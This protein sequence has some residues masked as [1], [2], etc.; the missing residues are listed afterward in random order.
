MD[1]GD[2]QAEKKCSPGVAAPGEPVERLV[3]YGLIARGKR[4]VARPV[5]V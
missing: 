3:R 1:G 2:F 5:P 4:S